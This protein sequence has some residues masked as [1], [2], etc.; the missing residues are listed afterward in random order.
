MAPG[1]SL[2]QDN[3][4]DLSEPVGERH[5]PWPFGFGNWLT[6]AA[7][8]GL[9]AVAQTVAGANEDAARRQMRRYLQQH[10]EVERLVPALLDRGDPDGR[11]F[12]L[13]F[14]LMGES[15]ALL[16]AL[17]DFAVSQR[18]P[19][20]LRQQALQAA[21]EAELIAP[22]LVRVWA[23]GEWRDVLL[24][25]FEVHEDQLAEHPPEVEAWHAQALEAF[26]AGKPKDAERLLQQA[27][28]VQPDHPSLLNNLASAY[29]AQGRRKESEALLRHNYAE[30]PDYLFARIGMARLAIRDRR[31]DEAR[32]LL[33]PLLSQERFHQSEF[34][35]L[36]NAEIELFMAEGNPDAARSWLDLWASGDPEHPAIEQWRKHLN[37]AGWRSW[38]LGQRSKAKQR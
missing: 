13:R 7:I 35:A 22:G 11:E 28:A 4:D 3:L 6:R 31:L 34:A 18:G 33:Q 9:A 32:D 36:A 14:A 1:L 25:S 17:R 29:E 19:D 2:V 23:Q 10:P 27:L 8:T 38:L 15:P 12:A 16:A 30:H 37:P 26:H 20:A 24:I 5:A 21:R